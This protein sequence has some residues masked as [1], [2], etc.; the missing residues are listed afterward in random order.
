MK[1]F[2]FATAI[3]SGNEELVVLV[4][5]QVAT[6]SALVPGA[7]DSF[8]ALFNEWE[9]M[10]KVVGAAL[11]DNP[12]VDWLS[13]GMTEFGIPGTARPS[14]YCAGANYS[15]HIAEM[16]ATDPGPPFHFVSPVGVL[17]THG[18]NVIRPAGVEKLDWE[19]ELAV[20]IGRDARNV[21]RAEALSYV[22]GYTIANDISARDDQMFHPVFGVD[23]MFAK[24]GEGQTPVGPAITPAAFVP[25][26]SALTLSLSVNGVV[27][28]DSHTSQLIV[29]VAQ[30]IEV[31]SRYI[32]LRP[33]DL[34]LTGTPAGT[35]AAHGVYLN[36]GDVV[37]ARVEELGALTNTIVG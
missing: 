8:D 27:R 6:L 9:T 17:N 20:V 19:V 23:W 7:P 15:D 18:A 22:A 24:N 13:A 35:A 28:Q 32:T 11:E 12:Q 37:E 29:N 5:D 14:I 10:V 31:L 25:D 26:P 1:Q 34:I 21:S 30:Q 3:I 16:G 2:G 33:G 4:E 36:D